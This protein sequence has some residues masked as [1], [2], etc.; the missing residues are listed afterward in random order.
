MTQPI[1][2]SLHRTKTP[3]ECDLCGTNIPAR[4]APDYAEFWRLKGGSPGQE[5]RIICCMCHFTFG[6]PTNGWEV[7][8]DGRDVMASIVPA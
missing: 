8:P 6:F 1:R 2:L 5:P 3:K 4:Q 7:S